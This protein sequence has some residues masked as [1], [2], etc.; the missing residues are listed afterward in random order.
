[1]LNYQQYITNWRKTGNFPMGANCQCWWNGYLSW[2]ATKL[3][4]GEERCKGGTFENHW[5]QKALPNS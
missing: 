3:H 5:M 2:Y 4:I 1:L